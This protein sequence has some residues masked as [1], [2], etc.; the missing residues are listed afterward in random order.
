MKT[1]TVSGKCSDMCYFAVGGDDGETIY[2][3]HDGYVPSGCGVGG[4]DYIKITIDVE[5]GKIVGWNSENVKQGIQEYIDEHN[6][7]LERRRS[8]RQLDR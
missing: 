8:R 3:Q 7:M 6:D 2:E 4:G 5:T 1:I